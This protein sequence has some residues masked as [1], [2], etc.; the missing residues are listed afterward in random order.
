MNAGGGGARAAAPGFDAIDW[1][2]P[3]LAPF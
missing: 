3:W 1:A 2:A